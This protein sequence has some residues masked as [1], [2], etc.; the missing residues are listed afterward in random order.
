MTQPLRAILFSLIAPL[1]ALHAAENATMTDI[2]SDE[3]VSSTAGSETTSI[4]TGHVVLMG[5]NI[6]INCDYLK[7][8]S[9]A[10]AGSAQGAGQHYKYVLATGHVRIVEGDLEATCGRAEFLPDL[11]QLTMRENPVIKD[12]ARQTVATGE[13]VI[14]TGHGKDYTISGKNVHVSGL[15]PLNQFVPTPAL[16]P[17]AKQ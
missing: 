12:R 17:A 13:P 8:I 5:N 11:E 7:A 6:R 3:G 15:A 9:A 1:A 16:A 10:T 2:V 4:L 14:L